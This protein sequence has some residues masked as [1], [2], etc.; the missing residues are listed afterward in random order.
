MACCERI[1]NPSSSRLAVTK[2]K[3]ISCDGCV[4]IAEPPEELLPPCLGCES[5][6][7]SRHICR[8]RVSVTRLV[9]IAVTLRHVYH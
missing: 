6:V 2:T 7:N 5:G 9:K 4:T 1:S 8:G 3:D